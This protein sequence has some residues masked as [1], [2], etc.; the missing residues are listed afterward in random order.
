[1]VKGWAAAAAIAALGVS[2]LAAGQAAAKVEGDTVYL[3][4]AVSLTGKYTTAGEH[5]RRGY[6]LAVK[7]INDAG[8]IT[9]DGKA[10]RLEVI[11]YDDESTPARG[12]Q[13]AERLINQDDV[14]Y[15]LGPYSSGLTKAIAP[16]TEKH[17]VPM[18]EANGASLQPVRPTT[19]SYLFA[20]LSTSEQYLVVRRRSRRRACRAAGPQSSRSDSS[21]PL[22][23]R[24]TPSARMSAPE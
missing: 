7:A 3:G 22:P 17:G 2:I 15:M 20:V 14:D 1:M 21:S 6:D 10:Y 4:A 23:S 18:V 13:L 16:V 12:A 24:T 11:Y 5:T 8:G 9:V 19:T